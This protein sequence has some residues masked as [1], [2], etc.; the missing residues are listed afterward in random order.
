MRETTVFSI[1]D[2]V[3]LRASMAHFVIERFKVEEDVVVAI[4]E[5][6]APVRKSRAYA[7]CVRSLQGATQYDNFD[8]DCLDKVE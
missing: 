6:G 1:G 8:L 2:K 4:D 3:R 5:D 7:V